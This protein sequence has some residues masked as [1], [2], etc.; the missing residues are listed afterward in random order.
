MSW[1]YDDLPIDL[2]TVANG[3]GFVYI[4]TNL[5]TQ[6][7][8]IGRKLFTKVAYKTTKGKRKRI[9]VSSGWENYWGSNKTLLEDVMTMG[10][11]NFHR[12]ILRFCANRSECAYWETYY[13]FDR[14]ALL[15]DSYY[16]EWVTCKISKKN[17]KRPGI[18]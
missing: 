9:R 8:Y 2:E 14:A 5:A 3:F 1:T 15:S 12:R 7:Q 10:E 17:I 18:T 13:I 11:S 4:I 6:R 16:N